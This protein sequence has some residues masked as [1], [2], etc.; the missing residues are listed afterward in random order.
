MMSKSGSYERPKN[1]VQKEEL[2]IQPYGG[3]DYYEIQSTT[4][5]PIIRFDTLYRLR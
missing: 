2:V 3:D 5:R 4:S 1:L